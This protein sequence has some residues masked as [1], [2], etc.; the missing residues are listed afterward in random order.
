MHS[1]DYFRQIE[2]ESEP[3]S[4]CSWSFFAS[5]VRTNLRRDCLPRGHRTPMAWSGVGPARALSAGGAGPLRTRPCVS[6][7][8]TMS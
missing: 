6:N 3:S 2:A 4:F 8:R 5:S 7:A 1:A